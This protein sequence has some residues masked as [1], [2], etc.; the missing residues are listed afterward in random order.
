MVDVACVL[1]VRAALGECPIW[2]AE[3][4][5]VYW[6]NIDGRAINRFD[7]ASRTNR[8]YSLPGQVGSFALR[9]A[10]G[11]LVALRS[12]F[13]LYDPASGRLEA[14]VAP[15]PD[16]PMNRLNDGRCD[17]AGRFWAGTMRDPMDHSL[18]EGALYRLGTGRR[19]TR[20]LDGIGTSNGMAFSPDGR[21]F[22]LADTNPNVQTIWAFNFDAE[23]GAIANRRVFATTHD[24]L[25][26]PDGACCDEEG[27]YW[28]ASV[29]GWCVLRYAPDGRVIQRIP[30][31]VEKPSMVAFGGPDLDVLYI[32]SIRVA[33]TAPG[34]PQ[35]GSLFACRPGARGFAEPRYGG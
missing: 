22:Y 32:T 28:S 29:Y 26:R 13:H 30:V 14:I 6:A 35:A 5:C 12:G 34:Q 15:E 4:A 18:R 16:K 27:C 33:T 1:D 7:P 3:E 9:A 19:V 31:P 11:L 21:T 23:T 25:G 24:E 8:V 10:G 17:P 2:C 20:M